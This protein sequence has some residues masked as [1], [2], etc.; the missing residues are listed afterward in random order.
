MAPDL[1]ELFKEGWEKI[2]IVVKGKTKVAFKTPPVNGVRRT[3]RESRDLK[4]G[5]RHLAGILFPKSKLP[6][7]QNAPTPVNSPTPP[8]APEAGQSETP[9]HAP[10]N[11]DR[12]QKRSCP[13][14]LEN[15]YGAKEQVGDNQASIKRLGKI[16]NFVLK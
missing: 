4:V 2:E 7:T 10:D 9:T 14:N 6:R 15:F 8:E 3:V 1:N 13:I 5:E 16:F 11:Q 12:N